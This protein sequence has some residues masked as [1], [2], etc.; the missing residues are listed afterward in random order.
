MELVLILHS[1][2]QSDPRSPTLQSVT[3][4]IVDGDRAAFD[5]ACATPAW[6]T[7]SHLQFRSGA[8]RKCALINTLRLTR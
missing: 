1:I 2:R 3:W 5:M 6:P 4:I 7:P 8:R